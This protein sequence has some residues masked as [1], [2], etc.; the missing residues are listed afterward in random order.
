MG[1][2]AAGP[3][4][5]VGAMPVGGT[6][7]GS[8]W[9]SPQDGKE[10]G[11]PA[12]AS[13]APQDTRWFA[14]PA[15]PACREVSAYQPPPGAG[16]L[17][18]D[19]CGSCQGAASAGRGARPARAR[20]PRRAGAVRAARRRRRG[21]VRR[22]RPAPSGRGPRPPVGWCRSAAARSGRAAGPGRRRRAA[23]RAR[24]PPRRGR[25]GW[26]RAPRRRRSSSGCSRGWTGQGSSPA[27]GRCRRA[28][29]WSPM[30]RICS[31]AWAVLSVRWVAL[32]SLPHRRGAVN[33]RSATFRAGRTAPQRP[34]GLPEG[35][36][37]RAP[38]YP[39]TTRTRAGS[40]K[41]P[42]ECGNSRNGAGG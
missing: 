4:A 21:A 33:R 5:G 35:P 10:P 18:G 12:G 39:L 19:C 16:P 17:S 13:S 2:G 14:S 32:R 1:P 31:T 42:T 15:K 22:R 38:Q 41:I 34:P 24:P 28:R 25:A 36:L 7:R 29:S 40:E 6:T 8:S 27:W 20:P 9:A 30:S 23:A 11:R 26:C 3:G 37:R